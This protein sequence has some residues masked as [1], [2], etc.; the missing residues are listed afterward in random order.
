[1]RTN[2]KSV[3]PVS[4]ITLA[5]L[6]RKF[7]GKLFLNVEEIADIVR[8][9]PESIPS[10][11]SRGTFPIEPIDRKG[12]YTLW[13]IIDAGVYI[14]LQTHAIINVPA[15]RGPGRPKIN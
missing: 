7:P 10:A 13:S 12:R 11:L 9:S 14:D 2:D 3:F 5:L 1:M 4:E 6:E 15:K 8:L